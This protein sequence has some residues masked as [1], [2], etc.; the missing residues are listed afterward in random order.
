VQQQD[1]SSRIILYLQIGIVALWGLSEIRDF[2]Q[3][4]A[5]ATQLQGFVNQG[6]RFTRADG[7]ALDARI[8]RLEDLV[9]DLHRDPIEKDA[10]DQ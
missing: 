4:R 8:D 7:D 10:D 9:H 5:E 6:A 3:R 2:Y 1:I